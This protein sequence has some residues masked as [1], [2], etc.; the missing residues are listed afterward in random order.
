MVI[1]SRGYDWK[2]HRLILVNKCKP[3]RNRTWSRQKR[4]GPSPA[5]GVQ[6]R[7]HIPGCGHIITHGGAG[8]LPV[9]GGEGAECQASQTQRPNRHPWGSRQWGT[10]HRELA[11]V[12]GALTPGGSPLGRLLGANWSS[13]QKGLLF[14]WKRILLCQTTIHPLLSLSKG[15]WRQLAGLR[16]GISTA[17]QMTLSFPMHGFDRKERPWQTP[18][19][20]SSGPPLLWMT[21]GV[22]PSGHKVI[23]TSFHH[24]I[25]RRRKLQLPGFCPL[26]INPSIM[27]DLSDS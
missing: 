12:R 13:R 10:V 22:L 8:G 1:F 18:Y 9:L 19:K 21:C 7:A 15:K 2:G 16:R 20:A 4:A 14:K 3:S 25:V 24:C 26:T 17:G 27:D 6:R 5:A 23:N 11:R